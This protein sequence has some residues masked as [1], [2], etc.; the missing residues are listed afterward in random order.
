MELSNFYTI[1]TLQYLNDSH[2][3]GYPV[4]Q[5]DVDKVNRLIALIHQQREGQGTTPE[6][7]DIIAYTTR[8]GDYYPHAHIERMEID[9]QEAAICLSPHTPFCFGN[10]GIAGYDTGGGPWTQLNPETVEPDGIRFKLF[11]T[12]GHC[13]RGR[14]GAVYFKTAVRA[15]K[16]A[17]PE[18]LFGKYTTRD[19]GR[20][21]ISRLPDAER[22]GEFTYKGE[23]FAVYSEEELGGLVEILHGELFDGI[24]SNSLVLWGYRMEWQFITEP[25]WNKVKAGLHLSFLGN[26][27][28]KIQTCHDT[29]TVIIYKKK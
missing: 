10:K 12:W 5:S 2:D 15:W 20:Y 24:Y 4:S 26:S 11:K 13:G 3:Y 7:G 18:P 16:Y 22:K 28:V 29:H 8:N 21:F 25:E 19:W 27:P 6:A 9:D 17:E 1:E 14:N 23:G